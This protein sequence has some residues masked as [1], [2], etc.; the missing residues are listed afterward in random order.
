MSVVWIVMVRD[1]RPHDL[2][3]RC[4]KQD[5]G[6]GMGKASKPSEQTTKRCALSLPGMDPS[7]PY[8]RTPVK[9]RSELP[10]NGCISTFWVT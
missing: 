8:T 10:T 1:D 5:L 2:L 7:L 4:G 6:H 9:R 3:V